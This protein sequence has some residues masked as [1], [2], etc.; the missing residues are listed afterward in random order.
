[1][2]MICIKDM[3]PTEIDIKEVHSS[4]E[5]V[6]GTLLEVAVED[7]GRDLLSKLSMQGIH[8]LAFDP[9]VLMRDIAASFLSGGQDFNFDVIG[10]TF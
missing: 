4:R 7:F 5:L 8:G 10:F 1:M 2:L 9:Q 3:S 6:G